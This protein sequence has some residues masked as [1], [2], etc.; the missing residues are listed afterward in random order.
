MGLAAVRSLQHGLTNR[1]SR[2]PAC[3]ILVTL[4]LASYRL[5]GIAGHDWGDQAAAAAGSIFCLSGFV[6]VILYA[7]TRRVISAPHMARFRRHRIIVGQDGSRISN[8]SSNVPKPAPTFSLRVEV[9]Q[10]TMIY[11]EEGELAAEKGT[12]F[13]PR[14]STPLV[15][16]PPATRPRLWDRPDDPETVRA[17]DQ[18]NRTTPRITFSPPPSPSSPSAEGFSSHSSDSEREMRLGLT[19]PA[20]PERAHGGPGLPGPGT[21]F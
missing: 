8:N 16:T 9:Q 1:W 7:F 19:L 6:D 11:E 10:D 17:S 12:P 20:P 15:H 5:A 13:S 18:L 14:S 3:F 4:P 2:Y 21:A